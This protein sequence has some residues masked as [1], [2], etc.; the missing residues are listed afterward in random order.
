MAYDPSQLHAA[1]FEEN[2]SLQTHRE[3]FAWAEIEG[4]RREGTIQDLWTVQSWEVKILNTPAYM[5]SPF[6]YRPSGEYVSKD[7]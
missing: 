6:P 3:R 1:L 5:L 2:S 7:L 4:R